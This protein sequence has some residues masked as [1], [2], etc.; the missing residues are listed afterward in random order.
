[1]T[2]LKE[3]KKIFQTFID[4]ICDELDSGNFIIAL[5]DKHNFRHEIEPTYKGGRRRSE[6]QSATRP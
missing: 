3:A 1:M 5:S 2:D 6:S 4:Q